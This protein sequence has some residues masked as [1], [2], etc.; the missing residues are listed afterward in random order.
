MKTALL[1]SLLTLAACQS[2]KSKPTPPVQTDTKTTE[3]IEDNIQLA[4]RSVLHID[5]KKLSI[6]SLFVAKK[7]QYG[8]ADSENFTEF[9][10]IHEEISGRI[11]YAG[12]TLK[13][14]KASVQENMSKQQWDTYQEKKQWKQKEI[15][16]NEYQVDLKSIFSS[17]KDTNVMA[18]EKCHLGSASKKVE[19]FVVTNNNTVEI[20][21]KDF[22]SSDILFQNFRLNLKFNKTGNYENMVILFNSGKSIGYLE[23]SKLYAG[24]T[25]QEKIV[26]GSSADAGVFLGPFEEWCKR[27]YKALLN[28]SPVGLSHS[29]LYNPKVEKEILKKGWVEALLSRQ[30]GGDF[31]ALTYARLVSVETLI[32]QHLN[33]LNNLESYRNQPK[34]GAN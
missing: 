9:F 18:I 6:D 31:S 24:S 23:D 1:L 2:D 30:Q 5:D 17:L 13:A 34:K 21:S 14:G 29:Y 12:I 19:N 33:K 4:R 28:Y 32:T 22:S 16:S 10:R 26:L 15:S 27:R 7:D 11:D 25:P 20:A 8:Y 3:S